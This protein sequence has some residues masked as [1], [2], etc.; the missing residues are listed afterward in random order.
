[1]PIRPLNIFAFFFFQKEK[2]LFV[3]NVNL[4][5]CLFF[6]M[7]KDIKLVSNQQFLGFISTVFNVLSP[8]YLS[9]FLDKEALVGCRVGNRRT[10]LSLSFLVKRNILGLS[11]SKEVCLVVFWS[12]ANR[13]SQPGLLQ[14]LKIPNFL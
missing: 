9:F 7:S 5:K 2:D 13:V 3:C 10:Q 14:L 1:M 6:R 11:L 12:F 8:Y 4:R